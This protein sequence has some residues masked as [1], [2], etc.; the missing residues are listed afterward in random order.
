MK[1]KCKT[2]TP[3]MIRKYFGRSAK[4]SSFAGRY[5]VKTPNGGKIKIS[6]SQI[7]TIYGG[8]DVYRA[9]TLLSREAWGGSKVN[10]SP[11]FK[12]AMLAHGEAEGV[13]VQV[14]ERG[15]WARMIVPFL[16]G[17][18]GMSWSDHGGWMFIWL[19]VAGVVWL[20]MK[21]AAKRQARQESDQLGFA[22]PRVGG[23]PRDALHE[24]AEREGW[25]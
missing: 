20:L 22:F 19:F 15:R 13:N 5:T 4:I 24:D 8:S 10:G 14:G 23:D 16:I 9:A 17:W 2:I 25:L 1:P 7:K 12:L 3:D 21:S 18:A 11:E 6:Q